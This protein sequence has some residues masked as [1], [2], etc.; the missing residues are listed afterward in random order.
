MPDSGTVIVGLDPS[1]VMVR[2]PVADPVDVGANFTLK[3]TLWPALMV[4]GNVSPLMVKPLPDT[5]A[6]V[7]LRLEPPEFV[8]VCVTV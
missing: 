5:V 3:L 1:E 6:A 2:L 4:A 8:S 7:T